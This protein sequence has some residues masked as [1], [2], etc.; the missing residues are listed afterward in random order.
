M[1]VCKCTI[2]LRHEGT[3]NTHRAA[4]PLVWLVE[5]GR[6]MRCQ[7]HPSRVFSL[8]IRVEPSQNRSVICM[9]FEAT[10]NDRFTIYPLAMMNFVVLD[11]I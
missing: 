8:K 6:G 5:G 9:V 11:L 10:A 1:D 3:L 2:L 7:G 4:N